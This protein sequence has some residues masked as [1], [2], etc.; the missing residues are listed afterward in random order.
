MR[1]SAFLALTIVF[2]TGCTT[3]SHLEKGENDEY[4]LV[5]NTRLFFFI[6]IPSVEKCKKD[7]KGNLG[8]N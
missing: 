7:D 2:L 1:I 3:Y 5:K 6:S 4:Y 8:C